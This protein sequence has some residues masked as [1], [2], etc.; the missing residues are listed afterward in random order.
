MLSV[1]GAVRN[2]DVVE[3]LLKATHIALDKGNTEVQYLVC[4]GRAFSSEAIRGTLTLFMDDKVTEGRTRR[5]CGD[6]GS[7]DE[8][9][10]AA[11]REHAEVYRRRLSLFAKS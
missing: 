10:E 6:E 5:D 11:E 4:G 3:G 1:K 2:R 7:E 8:E 9:L